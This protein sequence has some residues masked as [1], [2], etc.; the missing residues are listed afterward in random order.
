M[1]AKDIRNISHMSLLVNAQDEFTAPGM[2]LS[3]EKTHH[4]I[5]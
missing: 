1:K 4:Q 5:L 2:K 3:T